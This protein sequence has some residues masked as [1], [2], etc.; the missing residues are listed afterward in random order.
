MLDSAPAPETR[1]C[2]DYIRTTRRTTILRLLRILKSPLPA[3]RESWGDSQADTGKNELLATFLGVLSPPW[4]IPLV[5]L[6]LPTPKDK[7]TGL[8]SPSLCATSL[9][10]AFNFLL[11]LQTLRNYSLLRRVIS[12][13]ERWAEEVGLGTVPISSSFPHLLLEELQHSQLAERSCF[14]Q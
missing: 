10:L 13:T 2:S 14:T 9:C 8:F 12:K 1:H 7:Y 11:P 6:S 5:P 4:L 3:G